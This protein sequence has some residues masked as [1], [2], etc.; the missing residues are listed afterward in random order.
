M[1]I[2]Y[3]AYPL[4][5][6]QLG[7]A[8]RDPW[9]F[10]SGDLLLDA[11]GPARNRPRMLYLDRYWCELKRLF[12]P[13]DDDPRPRMAAEL[14]RGTVGRSGAGWCEAYTAVRG[15]DAVSAIAHDLARMK[16]IDE[17]TAKEIG[18]PN[19]TADQVNGYLRRAQDFT[20]GLARD[21]LGLVYLIG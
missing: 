17:A 13:A 18:R 7:P 4:R 19:S 16:P 21:G 2:R 6:D 12:A 14:V 20:A 15:P 9:P 5:P 3:Y 10:L 1:G 8:H 11:R